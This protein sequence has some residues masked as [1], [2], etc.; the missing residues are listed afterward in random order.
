MR[1]PNIML[2]FTHFLGREP[3]WT[4]AHSISFWSF[5]IKIQIVSN[6]VVFWKYGEKVK[7]KPWV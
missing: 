6:H 2:H 3:H 1:K 5:R 4:F 7:G